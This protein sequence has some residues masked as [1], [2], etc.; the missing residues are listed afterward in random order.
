MS[1]RRIGDDLI[2]RLYRRAKGD[3]WSLALPRF[4]EA[5]EVSAERAFAGRD[6]DAGELE[7]YL[8]SLHLEDLALACACAD[9]HDA[10][11]ELFVREH[12]P[13]LYRSAD[14]LDPSGG[15]R[16]L[17]DS[18]YGDLYGI[19][20]RDT[21][22]RSLFRYFHGRSSLATWLRAVLAQRRVDRA[23]TERRL[24]PLPDDESLAPAARPPEAEPDRARYLV[25][26]E[27]AL[28]GAVARLNAKDRLRL[29]CYY[30]Q[31]LTLA[32]T[33]R[34]LGEHEGS[35]S[36]HLARTRRALRADVERELRVEAGL[37]DEE[38]ARCFE[39]VAADAGPLDLRQ[40]I[41]P[42]GD[43]KESVPDR[44]V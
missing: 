25:L 36:R 33:G 17:A 2:A 5:L 23:R 30:A 11:W 44:S 35:A 29:R 31:E 6:P 39:S 34:L 9:G 7:R 22:R 8:T 13:Q 12:R 40:I 41:G 3:R 16:D 4:A 26:I 19:A 21:E 18:L 37:R 24:V 32:E 15:A 1:S 14:A 10:A 43:R 42:P 28:G 38:I 20:D 27:R